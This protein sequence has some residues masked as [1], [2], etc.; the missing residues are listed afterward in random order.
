MI[1][2]D[3]VTVSYNVPATNALRCTA[4]WYVLS[5]S[6]LPVTNKVDAIRPVL[7][8]S[9]IENASPDI[10]DMNFSL[11]L[12][13]ITP[14]ASAFTVMVNSVQRTVTSV[15][16]SDT[17]VQLKLGTPVTYG[18]NITVA[19]TVPS[20][21]ALRSSTGWYVLTFSAKTVTNKVDALRPELV[22]AAI[23]N[24]TPYII[25][26]TFSLNLSGIVPPAT[27]F[28]VTVNLYKEPL[29]RLWFRNKCALSLSDQLIMG[30]CKLLLT[31]SGLQMP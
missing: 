9:V 10:L 11:S 8:N 22:S 25:D 12:S 3:N 23:E 14:P 29:V 26:L 15:T 21:N 1:N 30:Q 24:N 2:G 17:R 13:G 5:F 19:Y 7:I 6:D 4:G 28:T 18:D 31:Q 16:V 27:A 20:T